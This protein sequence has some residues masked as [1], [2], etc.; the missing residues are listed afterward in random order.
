MSDPHSGLASLLDVFVGD[1]RQKRYFFST[2][3]IVVF[4]SMLRF[5]PP[6]DVATHQTEE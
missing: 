3:Y 4:V 2:S 1:F 6:D 5:G